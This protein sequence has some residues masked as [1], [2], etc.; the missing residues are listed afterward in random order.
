MIYSVV[1]LNNK[2]KKSKELTD[3]TPTVRGDVV[4]WESGR[5]RDLKEFYVLEGD[6]DVDLL[7]KDELKANDKKHQL[8]PQIDRLQEQN[9]MLTRQNALMMM[10]SAMKDS[11]IESIKRENAT[12][13]MEQ[14]KLSNANDN[15]ERQ[16][17]GLFM[18]LMMKG[19]L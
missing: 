11:S 14:A 17:S 18:N 9:D 2:G 8:K 12:L 4:Q 19:A 1:I 13:M 3:S 16:L 15:N 5:L 7:T 10:D 6:W